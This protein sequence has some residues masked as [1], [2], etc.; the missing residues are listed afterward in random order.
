MRAEQ[1]KDW[2][3]WKINQ[4]TFSRLKGGYKIEKRKKDMGCSE[5][6]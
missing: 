6:K 3:N 4:Q 1:K 2:V 5:Q